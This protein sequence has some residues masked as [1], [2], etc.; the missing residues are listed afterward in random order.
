[1][2]PPLMDDV[3][4][5]CAV[6]SSLTTESKASTIRTLVAAPFSKLQEANDVPPLRR[7]GTQLTFRAGQSRVSLRDRFFEKKPRDLPEIV[8]LVTWGFVL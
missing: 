1:M 3:T 2:V 8:H 6:A 5:W 7:L 4:T